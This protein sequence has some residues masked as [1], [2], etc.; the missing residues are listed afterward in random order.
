MRLRTWAYLV[1]EAVT[2]LWRY[3]LLGLASLSTVAICLTVLASVV[4][5]AVNLQHLAS[6]VEAQVEVVAFLRRDFDRAQ[7]GQLLASVR[8]IPGVADARFVTREEALAR[9]KRQ[10][11]DRADMLEG[12]EDPS[13]NPLRDSVE[14]HLTTPAAA[15]A[16]VRALRG[17]PEVAE[18]THDQDVVDRLLSLTRLLRL[19]GLV[20]V[21]LLAVV[22]VFVIANTVRLTIFA[23]RREIA[24]MKLVGATDAFIRW[25]FF[26]EG[27]L[28]GVGGA[29]V[30]ALVAALGYHYVVGMVTRALPFLPVVEPQPLLANLTKLLVVT[31]A[32]IGS[33]GSAL[34]LRRFLPV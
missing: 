3:R 2:G 18:V 26:L 25:P 10:L 27:L 21:V 15:A 17:M 32:L 31:G 33:L 13:A 9:L 19:M 14:I 1:R 11:G 20:L 23:R 12:L 6:F 29:L 7:R 4:L 8:A 28:V 30:A 5:L 24:I 22:T 16:V 34:S